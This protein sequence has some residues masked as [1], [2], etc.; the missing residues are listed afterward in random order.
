MMYDSVCCASPYGPLI[1]RQALHT[2]P[3]RKKKREGGAA[4]RLFRQFLVIVCFGLVRAP[5]VQ[6]I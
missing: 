6:H 2:T 1:G 3:N 4:V 5:Y